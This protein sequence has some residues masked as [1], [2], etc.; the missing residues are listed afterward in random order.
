MVPPLQ[1]LWS[2]LRHAIAVYAWTLATY[3]LAVLFHAVTGHGALWLLLPFSALAGYGLLRW[4]WAEAPGSAAMRVL[5][6]AAAALLLCLLAAVA[7]D[8]GLL[9]AGTPQAPG[10]LVPLATAVPPSLPSLPLGS[11]FRA[12]CLL[13]FWPGAVLAAAGVTWRRAHN[14]PLGTGPGAV[15]VR[16]LE[17]LLDA[18]ELLI[19]LLATPAAYFAGANL[20][21]GARGVLQL[22]G[23]VLAVLS[24][25]VGVYGFL[26]VLWAGIPTRH[27]A[28][29]LRKAALVVLLAAVAVLSVRAAAPAL[30]SPSA[31]AGVALVAVWVAATAAMLLWRRRA[32]HRPA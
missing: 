8:R 25:P 3:V 2:V 23:I 26:R 15:P 12:F 18:A 32:A 4:I 13:V 20:A 11:L 7:Y 27:L 14:L 1:L 24:V 22:V 6:A 29:F 21:D 10:L 31:A 16:P 19:W 17:L 30:D 28:T 5:A 9:L